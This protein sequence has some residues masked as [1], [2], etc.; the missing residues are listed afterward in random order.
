MPQENISKTRRIILF[1]GT[2][3]SGFIL[4]IIPNLFFGITK[5]NGGLSGINLF[6]IALFQIVSISVLIGFSLK[7]RGWNWSQIG[8][9]RAKFKHILL[10]L[11]AGA[12][13]LVIQFYWLIPSTGGASRPDIIQMVSIMDNSIVTMLSYLSLGIIGGGIAEEIFNRGYFIRGMEDLFSNKKI[14]VA[15]AAITS[16]LF[17]VLGHLPYDL[18]STIDILV[19]TIIYTALFLSTG[20]LF[21]SIVAH[22]LYNG[23]AIILVYVNYYPG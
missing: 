7:K 22:S 19:P 21:P 2:I 12:I 11:L 8:W 23:L 17:F 6:Y 10:G 14:G 9:V 13:W 3:L 16:I 4:F 1:V 18:V 20:S 5:I 15:F